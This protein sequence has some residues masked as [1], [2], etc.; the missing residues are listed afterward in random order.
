[1]KS[2]SS[3]L[4]YIPLGYKGVPLLDNPEYSILKGILDRIV[5][6][7]GLSESSLNSDLRLSYVVFYTT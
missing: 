7:S 6:Y 2:I 3:I 5:K 1:M 4:K